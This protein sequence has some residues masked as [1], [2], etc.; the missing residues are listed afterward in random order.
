M[1]ARILILSFPLLF[2]MS[3]YPKEEAPM[4]SEQVSKSGI[5]KSVLMV[6]AQK[7]YRDEEYQVPRKVLEQAGFEVKVA[8]SKLGTC[9]G[10]LGGTLESDLLLEDV[11]VDDFDALLFIGGNGAQEYWEN[12]TAHALL[13]EAGQK[14]KVIGAICIAPVTLARAGLLK[15]RR[16]TVFPSESKQMKDAVYTGNDV[17]VDG[18]I[19]TANGPAAAR[20]FGERVKELLK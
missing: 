15:G 11:R 17:E 6:V 7:N 2:L 9:T 16:V 8:S 10:V 19:V 13:R 14:N 3:C 20:L 5:K 1:K 12:R 18:R 4:P